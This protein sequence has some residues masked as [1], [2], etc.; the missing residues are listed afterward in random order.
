MQ[1]MELTPIAGVEDLDES[2]LLTTGS[3]LP[4]AP[5][6]WGVGIYLAKTV[7]DHWGEFKEGVADGFNG[8]WGER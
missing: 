7:G 3:G 8:V 1:A 4:L 5:V 6:A 2:A